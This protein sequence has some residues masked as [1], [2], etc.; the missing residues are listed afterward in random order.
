MRAL[1]RLKKPIGPNHVVDPGD[2]VRT[3][4]VLAGMGF[5]EPPEEGI[6][7]WPD[8]PMVDAVA[9]FQRENGLK[10]DG[11]IRPGGETEQ[12][13]NDNLAVGGRRGAPGIAPVGRGLRAEALDDDGRRVAG[14]RGDLRG[15][16]SGT[17]DDP[18]GAVI[19]GAAGEDRLDGGA[20]DDTE[21]AAWSPKDSLGAALIVGIVR[22]LQALGRRGQRRPNP[23]EPP[24]KPLPPDWVIDLA[25]RKFR[26]TGK[27]K[28]ILQPSDFGKGTGHGSAVRAFVEAHLS[29]KL[30]PTKGG[31][32]AQLDL[33][34]VDPEF[35]ARV[36]A[37]TG[38][39]IASLR[40]SIDTGQVRHAFDRHGPGK[41]KRSDQVPIE[42][43]YVAL[44]LNAV[45]NFDTI[46]SVN[47]EKGSGATMAFTKRI[48]GVVVVV[49]Q[50]RTKKGNFA[51]YSM[52]IR[53]A[54]Q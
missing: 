22:G 34:P 14:E 24:P 52:Y 10:V 29:G 13:I 54:K 38:I 45:E 4:S 48:N 7:P 19:R 36:K 23:D 5:F 16:D 2:T 3:K 21:L 12:A 49:E 37:E 53:K 35:A 51:F 32:A 39:D 15:R 6:T 17:G 28:V 27:N 25:A 30:L 1:F 9:A 43:E 26:N 42:P 41:E 46:E 31:H 33:D 47:P 18:G 50:A 11:V 44:Y 8:I 40:H 20:G